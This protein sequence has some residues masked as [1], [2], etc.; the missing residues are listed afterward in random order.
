MV[1]EANG[2][3]VDA[4]SVGSVSTLTWAHVNLG[5]SCES[6]IFCMFRDSC[7]KMLYAPRTFLARSEHDLT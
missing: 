3:L 7:A 6:N 4:E 5:V 1:N 2:Q